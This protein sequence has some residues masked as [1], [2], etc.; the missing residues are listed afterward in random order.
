MSTTVSAVR[1]DPALRRLARRIVPH[2][3]ADRHGV[4]HLD[5]GC[6][7]ING[8]TRNPFAAAGGCLA[9]TCSPCQ[10]RSDAAAQ[11]TTGF[12]DVAAAA[13]TRWPAGRVE[14]PAALAEIIV[15]RHAAQPARP[16][17]DLPDWFTA[18]VDAAAATA[19]AW[20]AAMRRRAFSD[21]A[22]R[23][24]FGTDGDWSAYR[25]RRWPT[26]V[27]APFQLLW[28]APRAIV[29]GTAIVAVPDGVV[30]LCDG[31][32]DRLG[33]VTD[34]DIAALDPHWVGDDA[35][36]PDR[37]LWSTALAAAGDGIDAV[38]FA[39]RV[40]RRRPLER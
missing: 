33:A 24:P 39:R 23:V 17:L 1:A 34:D 32:L 19:G 28:A 38:T 18:R 36:H 21:A 16:P 13:T 8:A 3:V 26:P 29:D 35:D 40:T 14:H 11:V 22:G 37:A 10:F 2:V 7:R 9:G 5:T 30:S 31:H 12:L 4:V 6:P 15:T 25:V 20:R 27:D